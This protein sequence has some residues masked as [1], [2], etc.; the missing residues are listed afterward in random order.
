MV[1]NI[2][3]FFKFLFCKLKFHLLFFINIFNMSKKFREISK[4]CAM[5]DEYGHLYSKDEIREMME[6]LHQQ[7]NEYCLGLVRNVTVEK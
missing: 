6:E 3:F 7:Y 5:I 1:K 2:S 4:A